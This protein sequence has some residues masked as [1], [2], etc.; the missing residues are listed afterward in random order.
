MLLENDPA[1]YR[2]RPRTMTEAEITSF[3]QRSSQNEQLLARSLFTAGVTWPG[4]VL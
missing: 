4:I 3:N 1:T 2:E